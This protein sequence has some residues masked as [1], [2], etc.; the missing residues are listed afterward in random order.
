MNT[1][2]FNTIIGNFFGIIGGA[3]FLS[4][5]VAAF[6]VAALSAVILDHISP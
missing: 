3:S 2:V 1:D 6:I 5:I 4:F